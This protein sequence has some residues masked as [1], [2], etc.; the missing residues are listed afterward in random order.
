MRGREMPR[1]LHGEAGGRLAP[2]LHRHAGG[3]LE[4]LRFQ[5]WRNISGTKRAGSDVLSDV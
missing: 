2:S 1:A 4:S 5:R 3:E